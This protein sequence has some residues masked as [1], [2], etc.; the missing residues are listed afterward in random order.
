[1]RHV[2]LVDSLPSG[3][4]Q[5][6]FHLV[7]DHLAELILRNVHVEPAH[8]PTAQAAQI[9]LVG[10]NVVAH[11]FSERHGDNGGGLVLGAAADLIDQDRQLGDIADVK[12]VVVDR[13]LQPRA[14]PFGDAPRGVVA[15]EVLF[16]RPG[17][18]VFQ[19]LF[20]VVFQPACFQD[21]L[22]APVEAPPL[23]VHHLIVLQQVLAD[24]VVAFLH[25]FLCPF[26]ALGDAP[27]LDVR[28]ALQAQPAEHLDRPFA[29]EGRH[30]LVP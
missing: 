17:D 18:G 27:V 26:D 6:R 19:H 24:F 2:H 30:Q 10:G 4:Y 5:F 16:D 14:G 20:D 11:V 25:F 23:L 21:G 3:G 12:A 9:P 7:G 1:M 15:V 13:R 28:A 29:G 8:C 22:T